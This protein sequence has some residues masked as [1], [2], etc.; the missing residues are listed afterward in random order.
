MLK[1]ARSAV[2]AF[3]APSVLFAGATFG[4]GYPNKPIRI[5]VPFGAGSG[6]DSGTRLLATI[7]SGSLG[8]PVVVENK[9]G[10]NGAIGA[11]AA[12]RAAPDGYTFLMGNNSTHGGN[13][14]VMKQPGYDPVKDFTPVAMVGIFPSFLVVHPSVPA[15]TP[16]ELVAYA[17]AH[18]GALSY[19]SG[20]TSSL[21]MA[22]A[23]KKALQLDILRVPYQSNPQGLTDVIGGRVSMMFPDVSSSLSHVKSGAVRALAIVSLGERSP[24]AP[25]VPT[26]NES[27]MPGFR[28]V[29]WIGLFAPAGTP[30]PVIDRVGGEI[31]KAVQNAEFQQKLTQLGAEAKVMGPADFQKFV[32]V[33]VV[34][35]PQLLRDA[36]VTPE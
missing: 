33:E 5:V 24:L 28:Y 17:K 15:K 10:A 7:L 18:P 26:I 27:V 25:D 11:Q 29:G 35:M 20:N 9:P 19:A 31:V 6:T 8:Q 3:L 30:Q 14:A 16:A 21:A 4:Q 32:S 34:R 2:V 23:F 36:G 1:W 12:A 22:E 13:M